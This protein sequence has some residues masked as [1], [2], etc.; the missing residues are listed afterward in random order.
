MSANFWRI[1]GERPDGAAANGLI[2]DKRG[3]P[4]RSPVV[5]ASSPVAARA[6]VV[7][8]SKETATARTKGQRKGAAS[9][10]AKRKTHTRVHRSQARYDSPGG[11]MSGQFYEVTRRP[12]ARPA[13]IGDWTAQRAIPA[14]MA[15]AG[16]YYLD[17]V[18]KPGSYTGRMAFDSRLTETLT[19]ETPQ[20]VTY[21]EQ[22]R[23]RVSGSSRVSTRATVE[24]PATGSRSFADVPAARDLGD[25]SDSGPL[26]TVLSSP[27]DV[28]AP[29]GVQQSVADTSSATPTTAERLSTAST[30]ATDASHPRTIVNLIAANDSERG[31]EQAPLP[32]IP[33][34]TGGEEHIVDVASAGDEATTKVVTQATTPADTTGSS[35][36]DPTIYTSTHDRVETPADTL[37]P[38]GTKIGW[39][40]FDGNSA[41]SSDILRREMTLSATSWTSWYT[42]D[43]VYSRDRLAEALESVRRYYLDRG[44]LEFRND[45]VRA[46]TTLDGHGV[47]LAV[48]LHE[49]PQY[50][51]SAVR[52]VGSPPE[53]EKELEAL[54]QSQPGVPVA[55]SKLLNTRY[56]ILDRLGAEGYAYAT[57]NPL[58]QP[59]ATNH[60]IDLTLKIDPGPRISVRRV[61]ITGNT[62]TH[63]EVVRREM[64]QSEGEWFDAKKVAQS[65][66]R[67]NRLGYFS[68][69]DIKTVPADNAPDKVDLQVRVG[70]KPSAPISLGAGYS[71]S[72]RFVASA[73]VAYDNVLGTG[74]S[75]GAAFTTG[76]SFRSA[77]LSQSNPY[78]TSN[79]VRR[80]TRAY[81]R[82][83]E[84]LYYSGDSSFKIETA[85][86]DT[87]FSI[88]VGEADQVHVG[89]ALEHNRLVPDGSTP[90]AY[91]DYVAKHG[92]ESGNIPITFAWSRDRLD[93][94]AQPKHG[95]FTQASVEYGTPVAGNHYYKAD[96]NARWYHAFAPGLVLRASVQGGYGNGI[97]DHPYPIFKNYYAGGIGSV[98]GYEAG[99][100][101][102]RD[103]KTNQPLGGS[104][105]LA[106]SIEFNAPLKTLG[107]ESRLGAVAFLDGGNAWGASGSTVGSNGMRF[108]Y[109]TG[110]AWDSPIGSFRVSLGLPITRHH[111]DRYQKIQM[112]FKTEL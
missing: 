109:G 31:D 34:G 89:A 26:S 10:K 21:A 23:S 90:A 44:Y 96:V 45:S 91:V 15:G 11:A 49:G 93:G 68:D 9:V 61:E 108:S 22:M 80:T 88:P 62:T 5:Q 4:W 25:E 39:I 56:A 85:G 17:G 83:N 73:N 30:G 70:E 101:S 98:R 77:T 69:V 71:S 82:S 54:V 78:F 102:P 104:K 40:R 2:A 51:L 57:V 58:L 97:G 86:I 87:R 33:H 52:I 81:Y 13:G 27:G 6:P 50:S 7:E 103:A 79:G 106:G 35:A 3:L 112:E 48:S 60:T 55:M 67:L 24:Q 64:R 59:D 110:F 111:F 28:P 95:Y 47:A 32:A 37:P 107:P 42:K 38:D 14:W 16:S 46:S 41:V 63:D 84:P 99:T 20:T 43:N 94:A 18:A 100:L 36:T 66:K 53:L 8:R 1:A 76:K 92:S 105:M 29:K 19:P 12:D 72:E 65:R 75:L 74:T